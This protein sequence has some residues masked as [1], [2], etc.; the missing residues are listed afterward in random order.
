MKKILLIVLVVV[1]AFSIAACS[2]NNSNNNAVEPVK[3]AP[4]ADVKKDEPA[5]A[6]AEET[7]KGEITVL[8]QRTDIVDTVFKQQYLPIFNAK[9][10]DIKV[11]F[12]AVTDYEGSVKIR[13]NTD[14]YGDLLLIP[15]NLTPEDLPTYFEPLGGLSELSE[16]YLFAQEKAYQEK[17]YGL[18]IVVN[19]QGIV[20]NSKYSKMLASRS[21]RNR[22][23]NS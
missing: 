4:A 15:N 1:F 13:M 9:Y 5:P 17:V 6:P 10:P 19:A 12:E 16:K 21:F 22:Q 8:T 2:S 7:I 23:M 20:Y 14:D 11:N 18:P 3:D